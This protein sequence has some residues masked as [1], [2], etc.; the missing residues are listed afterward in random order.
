MKSLAVL[1]LLISLSTDWWN[2]PTTQQYIHEQI[3]IAIADGRI[4]KVKNPLVGVTPLVFEATAYESSAVSCGYWSRFNR[5][6]TGI[7]PHRG[8]VAVD[9]RV[10]P[11]HTKLYVEGYG[12]A[13][14]EDI[15]GAIKGRRIDLYMNTI[16]E[17][18]RWGRK[19]VKVYII[20]GDKA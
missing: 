9:M 17:C 12:W 16:R 5:T 7:R 4:K 1:M 14:A 20:K 19:K 2:K 11:M 15:G 10:I 6:Y 8:I 3:K 18:R 13:K